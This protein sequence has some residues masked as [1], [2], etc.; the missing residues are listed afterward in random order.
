VVARE[1]VQKAIDDQRRRAG[2]ARAR[3]LE[4]IR[5]G[6]ILIDSAG[7][8]VGQVNGLSVVKSGEHYFG[9]VVR[10][11]AR[12][13]IG[14]GDVIDIERDVELAGPLH[15][16][17]VLIC[18]ALLGARYA[19]ET[20]LSLS[21]SLVFEQSYG[22]VERDSASIAEA[23]AL[24]S[25]LAEQPILQSIAV[26]GSMNQHGQVQAIGGVNEKIEGFFEVCSE[27]GLTG[28]QGVVIPGINARHLML[29]HSVIAAVRAGKFHIW[30]V[31]TLDEAI[32]LLT[33]RQAGQR[34]PRGLYPEGSINRAVQ[35]RLK[36][37]AETS[38]RFR[39]AEPSGRA[40]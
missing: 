28:S 11:T 3:L 25:A 31:D 12:A 7:G 17:G 27:R 14:R 40:S 16:K 23:C 37:F 26:T 15:A 29:H 20:P 24:L 4:S 35:E 39:H 1:H 13:W 38:R 34:D 8:R 36:G 21:A 30:G 5:H 33:G 22:G 18:K 19:T 10:I 6:V 32:E 2:S 9:Q